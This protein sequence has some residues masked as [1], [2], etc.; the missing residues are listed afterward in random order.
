MDA[1]ERLV[2]LTSLGS[3]V[4][5]LNH[6]QHGDEAPAID[7]IVI[8]VGNLQ[9]N[10]REYDLTIPVCQDCL[11]AL[12]NVE[13]TLLFCLECTSSQWVLNKL[14]KLDYPKSPMWLCGCPKCKDEANTKVFM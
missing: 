11:D 13:W 3:E 2:L 1:L 14:S 8:P 5:C 4:C 7:Y 6:D 10:V 9:K 12:V